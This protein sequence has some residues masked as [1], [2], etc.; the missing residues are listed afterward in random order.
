MR[1]L[2]L[3]IFVFLS[4]LLLRSCVAR[5]CWTR[6]SGVLGS[7][8]TR[9][10]ESFRGSVLEQDTFEPSLLLIEPRKNK[11]NVC[12]C[13]DMTEIQLYNSIFPPV[14]FCLSVSSSFFSSSIILLLLVVVVVVGLL[15]S[16]SVY[17]FC[18][19][20]VFYFGWLY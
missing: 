1:R 14:T 11:S 2:N 9:S 7:S 19:S 3:V 17:V 13:R 12:S 10:S 8:C 6:S 18:Y 15:V 20:N 4:F 16:K 5:W